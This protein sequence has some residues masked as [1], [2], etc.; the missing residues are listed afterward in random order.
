MPEPAL[1]GMFTLPVLLDI[2]YLRKIDGTK[3][4]FLAPN[5]AA[6]TECTSLVIPYATDNK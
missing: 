5:R 3:V 6:S 4:T 2:A 1:L